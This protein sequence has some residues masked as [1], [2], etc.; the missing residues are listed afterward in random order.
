[1]IPLE[2]RLKVIMASKT[3]NFLDSFLYQYLDVYGKVE[4][5][6]LN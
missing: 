1:M 4:L 5:Y 6:I 3:G 2:V